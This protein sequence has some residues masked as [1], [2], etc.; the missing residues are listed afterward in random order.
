M[1][2]SEPD[3]SDILGASP[4]QL[5]GPQVGCAQIID[6]FSF[7]I[8]AKIIEVFSFTVF[9]MTDFLSLNTIA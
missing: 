5:V 2:L 8:L 9:A 3:H 1:E 6:M 4:C 7:T